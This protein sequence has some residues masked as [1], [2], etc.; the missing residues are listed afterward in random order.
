[1]KWPVPEADH[2]PLTFMISAMETSHLDGEKKGVIWR[3]NKLDNDT[4]HNY[5]VAPLLCKL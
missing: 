5:C 3:Q 2:S 4:Q 1:V